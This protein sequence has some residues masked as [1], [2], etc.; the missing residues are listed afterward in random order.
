LL[1]I[2]GADPCVAGY[3][4][5][6]GHY[7]NGVLLAPVTAELVDGLIE[8]RRDADLAPFGMERFAPG[9]GVLTSAD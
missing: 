5:A 7:R 2:I 1:P 8:G 3:Y 6:C 9:R 4:V